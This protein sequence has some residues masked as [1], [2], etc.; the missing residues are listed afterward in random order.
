MSSLNKA[1]YEKY[2]DEFHWADENDPVLAAEI[3]EYESREKHENNDSQTKEEF[4]RLYEGNIESRKQYRF[5][6]QDELKIQR[7]GRILHMNKFM[8]LLRSAG[9]NSWYTNKGGM[10]RTLGLYIQHEGTKTSCTHENGKPH[11]VGFVQVPFMQEYEELHF[12]RY[13][14]P[15]GIKR[16]GWRTILLKLREQNLLTE[17]EINKVFGEPASG[18]VSRRYRQYMQYL[19]SKPQS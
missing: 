18:P 3:K 7:E 8:E 4:H 13:D 2:D 6:N 16:R 5:A 11:Y 15:L 14:V 9:L 12:D 10:A 17:P 19:R 1:S